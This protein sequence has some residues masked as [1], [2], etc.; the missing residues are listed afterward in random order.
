M[1]TIS[2]RHLVRCVCSDL[3][4]QETSIH[5]QTVDSK[6]MIVKSRQSR[7]IEIALVTIPGQSGLAW[8]R[9]LWPCSRSLPCRC[10]PTTPPVRRV[11][12]HHPLQLWKFP[13][14]SSLISWRGLYLRPPFRCLINPGMLNNS[15]FTLIT[16]S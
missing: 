12:P 10:F 16:L 5:G 11:R 6:L 1:F 13:C 15:I 14:Q 3:H 8:P 4:R 7:K 9:A 2:L